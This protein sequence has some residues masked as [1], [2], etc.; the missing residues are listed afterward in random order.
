VPFD[1][2]VNIIDGVFSAIV[3]DGIP[4]LSLFGLPM[5]ARNG[6]FSAVRLRADGRYA[7]IDLVPCRTRQ[8]YERLVIDEVWSRRNR[9]K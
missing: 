8:L 5:R 6:G 9:L 3:P 1:V 7:L 4:S 2:A